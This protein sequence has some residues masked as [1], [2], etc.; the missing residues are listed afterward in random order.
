MRR[1]HAGVGRAPRGRTAPQGTSSAHS[2]IRRSSLAKSSRPVDLAGVAGGHGDLRAGWSTNG[3]GSPSTSPASTTSS[4]FD[5]LAEANTSAGAPSTICSRSADDAGEVELDR[6]RRGWP[7]R[8]RRRARS[9]ASVS[10]AAANT[11]IEPATPSPSAGASVVARCPTRRRH[12]RRP[13]RTAAARSAASSAD[14]ACSVMQG[15]RPCTSRSDTSAARGR[16]RGPCAPEDALVAQRVGR[17]RPAWPSARATAT[18]SPPSSTR[19]AEL[20]H[21]VARARPLV[22]RA[23]DR[24]EALGLA[25]ARRDGA[26]RGRA[27]P[28][29][30]RRHRGPAGGGSA[31]GWP[32]RSSTSATSGG[33]CCSSW[34]WPGA[35]ASTQARWWTAQRTAFAG[36]LAALAVPPPGDDPVALWRHHSAAA[37]GAF[38][39]AY[40]TNSSDAPTS[41]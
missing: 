2:P 16:H 21:G 31:A 5:V 25:A 19:R 1:R 13:P 28:H 34:W 35:S 4:M 6:R 8:R 12:R 39:D 26:G 37:V 30:V 23:L 3:S 18:T 33:G 24:L 27:A 14:A 41:A 17:A 11:V 15:S 36:A 10:D 29:G 32:R 40:S 20:G 22:Y 38:L 7:P 9:K